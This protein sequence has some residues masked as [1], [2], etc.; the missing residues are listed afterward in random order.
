[1]DCA[2]ARAIGFVIVLYSFSYVLFRNES[3]IVGTV[4]N[5]FQHIS[6]AVFGTP[7][8]SRTLRAMSSRG[9]GASLYLVEFTYYAR[10]Q[11]SL[12]LAVQRVAGLNLL[13]RSA[14]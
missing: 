12:P 6:G 1:M 3:N 13:E 10:L 9:I 8:S 4:D 14:I 11:Q 7:R 2:M 5:Q